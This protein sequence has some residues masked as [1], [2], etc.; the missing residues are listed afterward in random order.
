MSSLRSEGGGRHGCPY[1]TASWKYFQ[2]IL[3]TRKRK[4]RKGGSNSTLSLLRR[5]LREGNLQSLF[6]GSSYVVP[7]TN[8]AADP[9][10][11][12]FILPMSD[13]FVSAQSQSSADAISVKKSMN[14]SISERYG[15]AFLTIYPPNSW[16]CFICSV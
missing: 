6:G 12:S 3:S 10:L 16:I 2:D 11:S 4:S 15:M 13:D 8:V 7:S 5:E 9:L 14:E 1:N